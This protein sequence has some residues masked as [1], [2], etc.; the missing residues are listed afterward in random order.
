MSFRMGTLSTSGLMC[1]EG[2]R[3]P[4]RWPLSRL[5]RSKAETSEKA[6]TEYRTP[7]ENRDHREEEMISEIS[8]GSSEAGVR[9][10]EC[11]RTSSFGIL[12]FAVRER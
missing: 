12:R 10:K 5:G 11:F 8:V 3:Q 2:T 9:H 6:N 4:C 1:E 7:K